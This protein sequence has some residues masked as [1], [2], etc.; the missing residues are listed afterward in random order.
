VEMGLQSCLIILGMNPYRTSLIPR[1]FLLVPARQNVMVYLPVRAHYRYSPYEGLVYT[2]LYKVVF[3]VPL[4]S[5]AFL[6]KA[7]LCH[8]LCERRQD[9]KRLR[10]NMTT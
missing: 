10:E 3:L 1:L 9:D 6:R 5:S 2:A 8:A 4:E 7:E